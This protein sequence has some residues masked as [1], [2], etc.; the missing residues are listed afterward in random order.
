MET[1]QELKAWATL[2]DGRLGRG[3]GL[4]AYPP[5]IA[6]QAAPD[7]GDR[8]PSSLELFLVSLC[9]CAAE[10]VAHVLRSSK[11]DFAELSVR[12]E[13]TR[14]SEHPA[15]FKDIRLEVELLSAAV[16]EE[17]LAEAVGLAES[18]ISPVW[19]MIKDAVPVTFTCGV[20]GQG[21]RMDA[22]DCSPGF[23]LRKAGL[24]DAPLIHAMQV[25]AFAPLLEKYRDHDLNP[26]AEGI[27]KIVA[28]LRQEHTD[29]HLIMCGGE[30]AG[31]VRVARLRGGLRCRISPIFVLPRFQGRGL[32]RETF[33]RL[34]ELYRPAEGWELD[35]ILEEERNC[36]L[37]EKLGYERTGRIDEVK[38]GMHIVHYEKRP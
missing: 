35:T 12:A 19:N 21:E 1:A 32:A 5:L 3:S 33:G 2:V 24:D 11:R 26:G 31:A 18:D 14:R 37:Y 9:G 15:H 16:A 20:R 23:S 38:E 6:G 17:E 7:G 27:E 25:E 22:R 4:R 28:R 8:G 30:S 29:Y 34:E 13:A 10:A 36:R